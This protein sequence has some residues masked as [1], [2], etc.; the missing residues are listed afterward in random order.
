[1]AS[2]MGS[3]IVPDR[4]WP[5]WKMTSKFVS[6]SLNNAFNLDSQLSAHPVE[7]DCP[8]ANKVI[9]I[10][11]ALSYSKAASAHVGEEKFLKGVSMYMKD[12]L[13]GNTATQ[14]LWK[15]ISA[16]TGAIP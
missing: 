3:A 10:F 4:L 5:E 16:A 7:V 12:N 11:D 15:G 8:D 6:S 9:Q 14:D 2:L 1:F 13:Y